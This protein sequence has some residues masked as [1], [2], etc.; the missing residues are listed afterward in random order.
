MNREKAKKLLPIITAFAEGKT[1]EC[2]Y[3]DGTW[4]EVDMPDFCGDPEGYRI[5]PS[6][7]EHHKACGLKVGD[8]VKVLRKAEDLEQGWNAVWSPSMNSSVGTI[9]T[10]K[11]CGGGDGFRLNNGYYYPYFVLEK[12]EPKYRPFANAEEFKPHRDKWIKYTKNEKNHYCRV[13]A[14]ND[15]D[16]FLSGNEEHHSYTKMLSDYTFEDGSPCGVLVTE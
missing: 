8:L 4:H 12:V 11:G 2:V 5:Q 15:K 3:G 16:W 13:D 7:L 10:I 9:L 6:Y 1:I 14:F